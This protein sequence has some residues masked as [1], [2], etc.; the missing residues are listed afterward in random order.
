M[1]KMAIEAEM[2][3]VAIVSEIAG[4]V[5]TIWLTRH[6]SICSEVPAV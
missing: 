3:K 4:L 2:S 1:P 5:R 6:V